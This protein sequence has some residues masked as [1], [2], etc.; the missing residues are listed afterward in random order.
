MFRQINQHFGHIQ[1]GSRFFPGMFGAFDVIYRQR[2]QRQNNRN[3][4]L[5]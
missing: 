1:N 5:P 2:D 3:L 4:C